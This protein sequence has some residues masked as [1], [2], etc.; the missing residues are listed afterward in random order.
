MKTALYTVTY[1]GLFYKGGPL[2]LEQIFPRVAAMGFDGIAIGAKRPVALPM[3]LDAR[4]RKAAIQLSARHHLEIGCVESYSNL[5]SPV[6]EQRDAQLTLLHETIQLAHDIEAPI[7]KVFAAWPGVTL[8]NGQACYEL[9]A[10]Y[11]WHDVTALE[12]WHWVRDS[13]QE[14]VRWAEQYGVRLALQNHRPVTNNYHDVLA[15]IKEIDSPWLKACIDAPHLEDQ[16]DEGVRQAV[17]ETG[18]LQAWT[19]FGGYEETADHR[20][21]ASTGGDRDVAVNYPAF[22]RSLQE[23]GYD[24]F[25][26]YEGCGPALIGHDFHGLDEVDRRA[27][28]ALAYMKRQIAQA[29]L[30]PTA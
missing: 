10:S 21:L 26:A 20:V 24:G 28:L 18:K 3:D 27:K 25:I 13:L 6:M 14:V 15:M 30:Q 12:Q 8:R 11:K 4:Q 7:V 17:Q 19:H 5:A 2:T 9:A 29:T 1:S 16:T 22:F 23:I